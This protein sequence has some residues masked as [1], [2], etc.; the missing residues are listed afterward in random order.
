MTSAPVAKGVASC[1]MR[2]AARPIF[3]GRGRLSRV[4]HAHAIP[5]INATSAMSVSS[6]AVI[7]IAGYLKT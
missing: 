1:A 5:A 4:I 7:T 3:A 6:W 2:P